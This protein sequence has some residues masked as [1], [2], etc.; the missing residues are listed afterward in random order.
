MLEIVAPP[1]VMGAW[2]MAFLLGQH[3]EYY[4]YMTINTWYL[5]YLQVFLNMQKLNICMSY[6][7]SL[8]ILKE[9]SEHHDV[10]VQIWADEMKGMIEAPQKQVSSFQKR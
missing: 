5:L 8:R 2:S 1:I 4:I 9:I 3:V 6:K 7:Q 10:E